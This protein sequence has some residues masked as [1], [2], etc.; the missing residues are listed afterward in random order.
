APRQLSAPVSV[1]PSAPSLAAGAT[2]QLSA[3]TTDAANNVLSGPAVTWSS[4]DQAKATV[5]SSG[6]VTAVA[7]GQATISAASE[8]KVGSAT[9]TVTPAASTAPVASVAIYPA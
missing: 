7:T 1:S 8:G 2:L 3:A 9:V 6:V 4:S 5:S